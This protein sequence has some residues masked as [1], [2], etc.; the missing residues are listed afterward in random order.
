[1]IEWPKTDGYYW[2]KIDGDEWE[3]VKVTKR[4]PPNIP[5]FYIWTCGWEVP[6]TEKDK[7]I[8]GPK[9]EMPK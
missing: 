4:S 2:A 3:I 6:Y 7:I 9:L 5:V 8:W 1:M